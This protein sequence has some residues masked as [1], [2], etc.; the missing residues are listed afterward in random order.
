LTYNNKIKVNHN[1]LSLIP[2]R[3]SSPPCLRRPSAARPACP[4]S[5]PWQD[6]QPWPPPPPPP[7]LSPSSVSFHRSSAPSPTARAPR[8]CKPSSVSSRTSVWDDPQ[9]RVFFFGYSTFQDVAI[10]RSPTVLDLRIVLNVDSSVVSTKNKETRTTITIF[11]PSVSWIAMPTK[12]LTHI[13]SA[14]EVRNPAD[15]LSA[16]VVDISK[17]YLAVYVGETRKRFVIPLSYLKEWKKS[18][19]SNIQLED[20]QFPVGTMTSSLSRLI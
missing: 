14:D 10:R 15:V 8:R 19:G 1:P 20:L 18:L 3:T 12:N 16:V 7:P 2:S 5:S 9:V 13:A 6:P 4:R 17:G 11:H